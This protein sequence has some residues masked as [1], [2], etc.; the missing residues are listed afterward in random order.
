LGAVSRSRIAPRHQRA[1]GRARTYEVAIPQ[2]QP[3]LSN[4][5]KQF[6]TTFVGAL[7]FVS[8]LIA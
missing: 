6:L 3:A 8:V 5:F 4:D 2:P 1:F 7:V